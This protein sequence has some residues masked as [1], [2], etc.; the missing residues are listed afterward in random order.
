MALCEKILIVGFSG[1]GKSSFL[2]STQELAP[3]GWEEFADLD[4]LI[5]KS[6]GRGFAQLS[7]L[8]EAHGWEKFRLWERQELEGWL[9]EEGKGVLALGGGTLTPLLLE[10]FKPIRK[11]KILHLACDFETC[12]QR[13]IAD[14][15]VPR[16]LVQ[17]GKS[18]LEKIYEEREKI[19]SRLAWR[20]ENPIGADLSALARRFWDEVLIS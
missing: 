17:K 3:Q 7:Q 20:L 18:E 10:H 11:I 4:Q 1:A 12:W 19:F 8:I 15:S 9:K 16:P 6:R 2:K 14:A 5:L 13:L